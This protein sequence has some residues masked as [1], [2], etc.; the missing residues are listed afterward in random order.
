MDPK[1]SAVNYR[2]EARRMRAV[3][4]WC[5]SPEIEIRLRRVADYYETLANQATLRRHPQCTH[6]DGQTPSTDAEH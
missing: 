2:R 1:R 3:A 4:A 5:G 6:R